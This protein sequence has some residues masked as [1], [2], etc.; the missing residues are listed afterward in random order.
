M[1]TNPY[2]LRSI[3]KSLT[4]DTSSSCTTDEAAI[5][6]RLKEAIENEDLDVFIDLREANEDELENITLF[7]ANVMNIYRNAVLCWIDGIWKYVLWL[8]LYILET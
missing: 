5:D 6:Q 7:G 3:Y 8:R 2:I 4:G 1:N